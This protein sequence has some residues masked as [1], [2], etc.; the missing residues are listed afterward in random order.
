MKSIIKI[1]LLSLPFVK[2]RIVKCYGEWVVRRYKIDDDVCVFCAP[3]VVFHGL[4]HIRAVTH[5][6]IRND[7]PLRESL[8]YGQSRLST[9]SLAEY[10]II[11]N[12][13]PYPVFDTEDALNEN[14]RFCNY[15][16]FANNDSLFDDQLRWIRS[17]K[18][19]ADFCKITEELASESFMRKT[20]IL[21][22][23]GDGD[24]MFLA[25]HKDYLK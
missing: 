6:M 14:R 4:H 25:I 12:Y 22:Y 1:L 20:A 2:G 24:T 7:G 5:Y 10:K 23:K 19:G 13:E 21:Y 16:F 9:P 17:L 11:C 8:N 15:F 3:R 18:A